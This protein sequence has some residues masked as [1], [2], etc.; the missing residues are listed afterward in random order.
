MKLK[1]Y[2]INTFIWISIFSIAMGYLESS[3]VV[4][5][6]ALLY[7]NGFTFPLSPMPDQLVKTEVLREVATIVML[8]GAG[9]MAGRNLITRFAWFVYAFAIWDIFYYVFL[10]L[11][12]DWPESL[13]TWDLLFLIPI[14]W[15]GPV[16]APLIV[17]ITMISLS[18]VLVRTDFKRGVVK[19]KFIDWLFFIIGCFVLIISF[20]IDYVIF[21]LSKINVSELFS[22]PK[23]LLVNVSLSY[24]PSTFNWLL[25]A[26]GELVIIIGITNLYIKNRD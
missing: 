19:T 26:L 25:F 22:M 17:S 20:T 13:F 5:L 16:I 2:P 7:P 3:V 8:A 14:T 11:L 24:I 1:S 10:K 6:R 4:Y 21:I 12:L 9:I 15:V 18:I 23:E